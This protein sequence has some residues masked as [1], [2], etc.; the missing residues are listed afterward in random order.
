MKH[1]MFAL[2]ILFT[3]TAT[4]QISF[5]TGI[6]QMDRDLNVIN[7]RGTSDFDSYRSNLSI[8]YSIPMSRIDYMRKTLNMYP[9]EIFLALEIGR[10]A[11]IS[12]DDVLVVY[13]RDKDKGWGQIAKSLGIKP[14]SSE[15][16]ALKSNVSSKKNK[17]N[18]KSKYKSKGK[19]K[20]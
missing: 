8:T 14:G 7:T 17:G 20:K 2:L 3:F 15:F 5:R 1:W 13:R 6:V 11:R 16:H 9:G 4:A 18:S 12:I 10:V 19:K